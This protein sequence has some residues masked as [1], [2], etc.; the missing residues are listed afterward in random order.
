MQ[1]G[2]AA[3]LDG[4]S[5]NRSLVEMD[6]R[7]TQCGDSIAHSIRLKLIANHN[8]RKTCD[9]ADDDDDWEEEEDEEEDDD[10]EEEEEEQANDTLT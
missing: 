8:V 1:S 9:E 10:E 2:G 4:L 7:E 5:A 6:M 3:L